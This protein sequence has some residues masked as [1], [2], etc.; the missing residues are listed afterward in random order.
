MAYFILS[1]LAANLFAT[2]LY[3][4]VINTNYYL[5]IDQ[6]MFFFLILTLLWQSQMDTH[7][8]IHFCQFKINLQL[9]T[10]YWT[11]VLVI[12]R[13]NVNILCFIM[14]IQWNVRFFNISLYTKYNWIIINYS[15]INPMMM[16]IIKVCSFILP[17]ID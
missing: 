12:V 10:F 5:K 8:V 16:I 1:I 11:N 9:I 7:V 17:V 2:F 15:L 3:N 13:T 6:K 4:F 14:H